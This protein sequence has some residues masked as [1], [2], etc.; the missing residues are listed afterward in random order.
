MIK[1]RFYRKEYEYIFILAY[2]IRE[3]ENNNK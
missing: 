3:F 2:N 1:I